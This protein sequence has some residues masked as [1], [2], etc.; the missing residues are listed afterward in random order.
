MG[1]HRNTSATKLT[2]TSSNSYSSSSKKVKCES[3]L[4]W[5]LFLSHMLGTGWSLLRSS[6]WVSISDLLNLSWLSSIDL[7]L[8]S[9]TRLAPAQLAFDLVT[10]WV[11][12]QC[13]VV[14][15]EREL[16]GT[17]TS[18]MRSLKL[19]LLLD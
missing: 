10:S 13:A 19:Q 9:L 8:L 7:A 18:V 16:R 17:I 14:Q 3:A 6:L 11:T 15:V 4:D 5:P 12:M 1:S 2:V